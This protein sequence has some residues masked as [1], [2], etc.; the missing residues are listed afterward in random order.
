MSFENNLDKILQRQSELSDKLSSGIRG[1]DFVQASKDYSELESTILEYIIL[2]KSSNIVC[3]SYYGHGS[4]FSEQCAV[5]NNIP[6][7]V[8]YLYKPNN[9]INLNI[10]I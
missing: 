6:Y 9:T 4:G 5:L 1:D 8:I 10:G 7:M 3:F 2:S